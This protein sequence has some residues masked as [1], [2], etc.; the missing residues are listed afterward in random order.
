MSGGRQSILLV[1]YLLRI[2]RTRTI[3]SQ[4]RLARF[5]L[6][7][8]GGRLRPNA[9]NTGSVR[10]AA[11]PINFAFGRRQLLGGA[12]A[13]RYLLT[14]DIESATVAEIAQPSGYSK[15]N[16][17]EALTSLYAAGAVALASSGGEQRFTADRS[18]WAHRS[19][20]NRRISRST[21]TGHI[22][23]EP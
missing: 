14:A 16:V 19:I 17:R 21:S 10:R 8:A 15:R 11:A 13:V 1:R 2:V 20:S 7:C 4:V 23:W 6:R 18:R 12:E 22:C 3:S 5:R 9:S